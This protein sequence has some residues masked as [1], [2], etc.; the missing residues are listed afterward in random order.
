[1]D[2]GKAEV[3]FDWMGIAEVSFD[4]IVYEITNNLQ[5]SAGKRKKKHLIFIN[6]HFRSHACHIRDIVKLYSM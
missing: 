6:L 1:M 4:C 3:S 5:Y 2:E